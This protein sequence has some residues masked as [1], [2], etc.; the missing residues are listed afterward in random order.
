MANK[1]KTSDKIKQRQVSYDICLFSKRYWSIHLTSL[2][3]GFT[4]HKKITDW[5]ITGVVFS[6]TVHVISLLMLRMEENSISGI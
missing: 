2:N 1:N 5:V 6:L 3:L 4:I